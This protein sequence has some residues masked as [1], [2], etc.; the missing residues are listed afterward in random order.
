MKIASVNP[1][2]TSA[3]KNNVALYGI[4]W[5]QELALTADPGPS[6]LDDFLLVEADYQVVP[7]NPEFDAHDPIKPQ[8]P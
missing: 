1:Y 2:T 7:S 5:E 3:D 6:P 8:E 4:T